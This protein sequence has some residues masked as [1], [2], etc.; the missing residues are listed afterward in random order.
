MLQ[1]WLIQQRKAAIEE[2]Y[3]D[4]DQGQQQRKLMLIWGS[5]SRSRGRSGAA[6][7]EEVGAEEAARR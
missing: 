3:V 7:G 2:E 6:V 1:I 5:N 4:A